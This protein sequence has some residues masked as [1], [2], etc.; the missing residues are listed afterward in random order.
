MW[1]PRLHHSEYL[2]FSLLLCLVLLRS[3]TLVVSCL[4]QGLPVLWSRRVVKGQ[5]GSRPE[6][7]ELVGEVCLLGW[8]TV[9]RSDVGGGLAVGVHFARCAELASSQPEE[10]GLICLLP[11]AFGV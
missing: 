5:E 4:V 3:A 7:L 2:V 11:M 9:V 1:P 6:L 8:S 10:G